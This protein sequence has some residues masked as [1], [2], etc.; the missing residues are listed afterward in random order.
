MSTFA[1]PISHRNRRIVQSNAMT[2]A[3]YTLTRDQK[4]IMY[5][6]MSKLPKPKDDSMDVTHSGKFSIY[7]SEYAELFGIPSSAASQDIRQAMNRFK[8]AEII[9]YRPE[10]D[11]GDEKGY[12]AYQWITKRG[13]RPSIGMY[14]IN[15]NPDLIPFM[16]GL[17]QN[18]T[19]FHLSE[20]HAITNPLVM[21][22][23]E[24]LCQ[25]RG[26]KSEGVVI[27]N[28]DWMR[29]RYQLPASYKRMADFKKRFLDVA[30]TE[31]NTKT[32]LKITVSERKKGRNI[33][34][35]IFNFVDTD[36]QRKKSG[37]ITIY[38]GQID[39]SDKNED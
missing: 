36:R 37:A 13:V 7:V 21:R 33:T 18:F 24:T 32:P 6:C 4:R 28:I 15:I 11:L 19:Q 26:A 31:I 20:I 38:S 23:Y 3:A 14:E 34:D 35:L 5:L 2:E 10:Y 25:Y 16:A 8:G 1:M 30:I 27:L 12:D 17:K 22:L 39:M 9:V 29:E